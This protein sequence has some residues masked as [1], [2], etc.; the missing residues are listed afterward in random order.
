MAHPVSTLSPLPAEVSFDLSAG[1]W[2]AVGLV[3]AAV[4]LAL[5]HY[6][7]VKFPLWIINHTLYRLHVHGAENVPAR[8]PCLLVSNHVS[9]I[10]SLMIIAANRRKVRFIIW[11][12]FLDIPVLRWVLRFARV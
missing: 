7:L 1:E 2:I 9:W 3:I 10:D 4:V 11:A 6:F 5:R 12:P 8:G